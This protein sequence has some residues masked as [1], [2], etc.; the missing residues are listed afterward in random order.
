[1]R[2]GANTVTVSWPVTDRV[3]LQ[4]NAT[5]TNAA[6]GVTSGLTVATASGTSR[7]TIPQVTGNRLFRLNE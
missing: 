3:T 4:Q 2:A 6:V 1:M 5:L 7:V